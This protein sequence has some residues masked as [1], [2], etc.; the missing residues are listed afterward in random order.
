M[1][2]AARLLAVAIDGQIVAREGLDDEVGHGPAVVL[3]HALAIRIEY[4]RNAHVRAVQAMVR[5]GHGLGKAL[6]LVVHA[7]DANGVDV[8][9]VLLGLGMHQGVAID[10]R[11]GGQQELGLLGPRPIPRSCAC[12]TRRP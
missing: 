8:A 2:D 7:A 5:H 6:G 12:P 3:A 1:A 9:E 11:R 10:F 4:A